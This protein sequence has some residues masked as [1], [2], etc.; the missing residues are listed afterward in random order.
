MSSL[1]FTQPLKDLLGVSDDP[2]TSCQ[3]HYDQ[4]E[5]ANGIY[6]IKVLFYD[7]F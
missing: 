5:R 6:T 1:Y 4:G 2:L 7:S 3:E